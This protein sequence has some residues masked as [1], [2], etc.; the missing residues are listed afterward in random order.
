MNYLSYFKDENDIRRVIAE[1]IIKIR[2]N[3]NLT[4]E[5]LAEIL[6]VS[7]EHIS[8][9]ENHKYTCSITL[10]FKVCTIFKLNIDEFFQ[11][12]TN[13]KENSIVKFLRE[14]P[15]EKQKSIAEFC[16]EIENEFKNS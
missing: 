12:S 10:I 11:I 8:R 3:N 15:I 13:N 9:I 1:S 14:L 7:V 4:Q 16:K 5:K 2:K 6:D